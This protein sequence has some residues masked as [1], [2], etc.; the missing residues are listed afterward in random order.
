MDAARTKPRGNQADQRARTERTHADRSGEQ[1][2]EREQET[3]HTDREVGVLDPADRP[4]IPIAD[5][6]H[7]HEPDARRERDPGEQERQIQ[8]DAGR[9]ERDQHASP[10]R[11]E[12]DEREQSKDGVRCFA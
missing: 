7:E 5:P 6:R 4:E 8:W 10:G 11:S 3:E 9:F 1:V 2:R 12:R